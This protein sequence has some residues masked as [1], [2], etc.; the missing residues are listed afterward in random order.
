M[1]SCC[2]ML[3]K[4]VELLKKLGITGVYLVIQNY[5]DFQFYWDVRPNKVYLKG[6]Y[7]MLYS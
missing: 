4:V 2:A 7:L 3:W 1:I 5:L 6:L